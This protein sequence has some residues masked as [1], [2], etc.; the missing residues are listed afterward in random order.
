MA[1]AGKRDESTLRATPVYSRT[2]QLAPGDTIATSHPL[3]S[4][5]RSNGPVYLTEDR[6]LDR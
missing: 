6:R 1:L 3:T 4:R 5:Q 2:V